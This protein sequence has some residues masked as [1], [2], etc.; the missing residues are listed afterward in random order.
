V[1][2][3]GGARSEWRDRATAWTWEQVRT[4]AFDSPYR[5]HYFVSF[6][7]HVDDGARAEAELARIR[8]PLAP[9]VKD[10]HTPLNYSPWPGLR[11]RALFAP[12]Q[13]ERALDELEAG[14]ADDGGWTFLWPQW[15]PGATLD[16][17]GSVTVRA[18]GVLKANG[19]L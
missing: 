12:E 11:S 14:Q 15:S 8:E 16:W 9:L 6:L 18:I 7:D 17:R 1:L 19:R 2:Y 3:E 10:E 13:I 5:W 4:S